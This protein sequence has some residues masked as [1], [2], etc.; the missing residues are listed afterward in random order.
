M[1]Q[2]LRGKMQLDSVIHPGR[3]RQDMHD[4]LRD[5]IDHRQ[6]WRS[7]RIGLRKLLRSGADVQRGM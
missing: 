3:A 5:V 6:L 7:A 1:A 2:F 4:L